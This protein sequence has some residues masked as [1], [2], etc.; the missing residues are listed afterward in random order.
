MMV[1]KQ[2]MEKRS[3]EFSPTSGGGR[4]NRLGYSTSL[5]EHNEGLGAN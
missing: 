5:A 2:S 4:V 3:T 1:K